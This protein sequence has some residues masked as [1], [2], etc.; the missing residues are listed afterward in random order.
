MLL[1]LETV[2][3]IH[4]EDVCHR[5]YRNNI[6]THNEKKGKTMKQY[7]FI[8]LLAGIVTL[9]IGCKEDSN[10]ASGGTRTKTSTEAWSAIM[11]NDS[12]N[13]GTHTFDKYSDGSV[14]TTGTWYYAYNGIEVECPFSEGTVMVNDSVV[15]FTAHGTA[16]NPAA[17]S[18]YQTSAFTFATTG[19]ARNGTAYGSYTISFTTVGW[20]T[21]LQGTFTSS[22]T[23]G[24]GITK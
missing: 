2:T 15:T 10:P 6:S 16:T 19:V 13:H 5:A 9:L 17:P 21:N 7:L 8:A 4:I 20:P 1:F 14:A 22:R 24:S 23:S 11:D 12:S 3:G 18:G